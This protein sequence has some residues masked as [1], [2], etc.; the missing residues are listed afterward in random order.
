MKHFIKFDYFKYKKVPEID[1][2][3]IEYEE[4]KFYYNT[5]NKKIELQQ[6]ELLN[7]GAFGEVFLFKK[8]DIKIAVKYYK[9]KNDNEIK[10]LQDGQYKKSLECFVQHKLF[11]GDKLVMMLADGNLLELMPIINRNKNKNL[12]ILKIILSIVEML[13]CTAIKGTDGKYI[14]LYSDLKLQNILYK[15]KENGIELLLADIGSLCDIKNKSVPMTESYNIY[16]RRNKYH[17]SKRE[18]IIKL[19]YILYKL[20]KNDDN[21]ISMSYIINNL[22]KNLSEINIEHGTN[23][24]KIYEFRKEFKIKEC[25]RNNNKWKEFPSNNLFIHMVSIYNKLEFND[26][27]NI[28]KFEINKIENVESDN[29]L[30]TQI[31]EYKNVIDKYDIKVRNMINNLVKDECNILS[32]LIEYNP[33]IEEKKSIEKKVGFLSENITGRDNIHQDELNKLIKKIETIP[34]SDVIYNLDYGSD[35]DD[36]FDTKFD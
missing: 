20:I 6:G 4:D 27:K 35:S 34:T 2:N 24:S 19:F 8:D 18:V 9:S 12:I 22:V 17:C 23:Y 29:N 7:K 1:I 33:N 3:K 16:Q 36:D 13:L 32:K 21:F 25:I 11:G 26:I 10:I 5:E 28:C 31:E 15:I 14:I 30:L